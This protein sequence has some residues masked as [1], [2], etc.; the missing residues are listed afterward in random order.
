MGI[1]MLSPLFATRLALLF[2][3]P[4]VGEGARTSE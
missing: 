3:L 1:R 4:F 2:P